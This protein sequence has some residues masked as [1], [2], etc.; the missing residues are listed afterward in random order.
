M[1]RAYNIKTDPNGTK[2]QI[3]PDLVAAEQRG[4]FKRPP[5]DEY[6]L[7]KASRDVERPEPIKGLPAEFA[8][9]AAR[10]T[11]RSE[12]T[13]EVGLP[14]EFAS[15]PEPAPVPVQSQATPAPERADALLKQSMT[16]LRATAKALGISL[17]HKGRVAL[18]REIYEKNH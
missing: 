16:E 7:R 14:A 4:I 3:L 11:K 6:Y 13:E 10:E 17:Y 5:V 2:A 8:E 9:A 12:W 1:A 18:A 15:E